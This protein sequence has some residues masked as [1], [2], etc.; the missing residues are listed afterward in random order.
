MAKVLGYNVIVNEFE[1]QSR[2]YIYFQTFGKDMIP[3]IQP[4]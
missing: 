4:R 1:L 3:V 2:Y